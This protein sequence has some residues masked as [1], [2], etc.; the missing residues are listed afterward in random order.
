MYTLISR[1]CCMIILMFNDVRKK[2]C[3]P[4]QFVVFLFLPFPSHCLPFEIRTFDCVT[5]IIKS[6][7]DESRDMRSDLKIG[8]KN[9]SSKF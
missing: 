4:K 3:I 8:K 9:G 5:C 1:K 2:Y 7:L 6:L